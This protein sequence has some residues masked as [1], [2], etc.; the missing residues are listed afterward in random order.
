[1]SFLEATFQSVAKPYARA[2]RASQRAAAAAV[3]TGD[4][5]AGGG[6]GGGSSP[7][8]SQGSSGSMASM[9]TGPIRWAEAEV[10]VEVEGEEL[11]TG[12]VHAQA[13][14]TSLEKG[15][16]E[17]EPQEST[18]GLPSL[19]DDDEQGGGALSSIFSKLTSN[20]VSTFVGM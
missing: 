18:S 17:E 13:H 11:D 20:P 3:A 5:V 10:K 12:V 6:G 19:D 8:R 16:E 1:M 14:N 4:A 7:L 9:S 2:L 15:Q